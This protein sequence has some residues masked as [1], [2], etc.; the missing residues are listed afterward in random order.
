VVDGHQ[1]AGDH[2]EANDAQVAAVDVEVVDNDK[3]VKGS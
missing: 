1:A 3:I 2:Q